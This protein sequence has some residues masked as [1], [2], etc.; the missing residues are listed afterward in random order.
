MDGI[1]AEELW[2]YSREKLTGFISTWDFM[3][4]ASRLRHLDKSDKTSRDN[5]KQKLVQL[6]EETSIILECQ[7]KLIEI[8]C[9]VVL[10]FEMDVSQKDISQKEISQKDISIKEISQT[11]ISQTDISQ[12]D[13]SKK[14]LSKKDFSRNKSIS[15]KDLAQKDHPPQDHSQKDIS[16]KDISQNDNF[17]L[18]LNE[19]ISRALWGKNRVKLLLKAGVVLFAQVS[20]ISQNADNF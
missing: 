14:G 11:D 10:D 5:S 2:N 3:C 20:P 12:N 19:Q 6:I 16:I 4:E 8:C 17:T 18:I 15:N 13:I 1:P 9:D 7:K